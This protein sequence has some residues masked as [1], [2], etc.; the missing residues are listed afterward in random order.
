MHD[1][2]IRSDNGNGGQA[3][4]AEPGLA[5]LLVG[6]DAARRAQLTAALAGTRGGA[7]REATSLNPDTLPPELAGDYDTLIVILDDSP[8][9]GLRLVEAVCGAAPAMTVMVYARGADPELVMRAMRA[10]AREFLHDPLAPSAVRDAMLRAS[11]RRDEVRRRGKLGK[12]LVFVGAKGGSGVSTVAANLAVALAKETRQRT[13]LI[14][15]DLRMGDVGLNLGVA[16]RYSTLDALKNESRLDSELISK[17]LLRH[18]S[19]L[20]VLAAPDE[21]N[22]YH[23]NPSSVMKVVGLLMRDFDWVVIDAGT[24]ENGYGPQLFDAAERVY[25]VTQVSV[26]ELR[27]CNRFIS[28]LFRG[29]NSAKLEVVVNRCDNRAGDISEASIARALTVTP[30]WKIPNDYDTVRTAQNTATALPMKDTPISRALTN[31]ARSVSGIPAEET[32][33]RRFSLFQ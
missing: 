26:P 31:M 28:A 27:N 17:F 7:V 22:S 12:C 20:E 18:E 33:K 30:A 5:V 25:L 15:L 21:Y 9:E 11:Q 1:M 14:D 16:G 13:V 8:D 23:P 3:A 32:R 29:K 6:A 4:T 10:G 24:H 2:E 19:G